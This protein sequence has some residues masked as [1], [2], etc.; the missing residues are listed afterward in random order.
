MKYLYAWQCAVCAK[1]EDLDKWIDQNATAADR[2][3]ARH[4]GR[5]VSRHVGHGA[6][7]RRQNVRCCQR[8]CV[9]QVHL[10]SSPP[11]STSAM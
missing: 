3:A 6:W 8:T 4:H 2:G 7:V 11:S 9:H 10:Y 1:V 5:A